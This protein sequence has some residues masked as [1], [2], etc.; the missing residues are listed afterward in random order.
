MR[1]LLGKGKQIIALFS[2]L[3]TDGA[4]SSPCPNAVMPG[5]RS[6]GRVGIIALHYPL[7]LSGCAMPDFST[8]KAAA[9]GR[10]PEI[11]TYLGIPGESLTGKHG[12]CPG[13]AGKDRFRYLDDDNGGWIC[14]Q[15]GIPTGGDG[16]NLLVH[17]GYSKSDALHA[18]SQY[19][20][21]ETVMLS[22]EQ[23]EEIRKRTQ[24]AK[25]AKIEAALMYE[26]TVMAGALSP[27]V[28]GRQLAGNRRFREARPEYQPPPD[29]TWNRE[30]IAARRI[31]IG[32]EVRYGL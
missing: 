30:V 14:G 21:I 15:G 28:T 22:P 24:A 5:A 16:F 23:R 11:L 6:G 1:A 12:P 31:K 27:R 29:D 7:I 32:L 4:L 25:I 20:N 17:I 9:A 8:V 26:F 19:L 18:V 10:W 3:R 13:C 2:S